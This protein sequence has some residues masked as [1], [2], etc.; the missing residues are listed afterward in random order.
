M[1]KRSKAYAYLQ[2]IRYNYVPAIKGPEYFQ[3]L[4]ASIHD[5][6]DATVRKEI[7]VAANSFTTEIRKHT[8]GILSD[9]ASQLGLKSE[10]QLPTDLRKLFSDLEFRSESGGHDVALSQ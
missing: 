10:I 2:S 3:K 1:P 9:L 8:K 7:R 4:L 6:L 5:M